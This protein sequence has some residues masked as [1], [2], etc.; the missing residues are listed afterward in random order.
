[1]TA[2]VVPVRKALRGIM[3]ALTSVLV[4]VVAF[5]AGIGMYAAVLASRP[6]LLVWWPWLLAGAVAVVALGAWWLWWRLP[7]R[8]MRSITAADPKARAIA[9]AGPTTQT[10]LLVQ[11]W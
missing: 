7:K 3:I 8:Q 4:I 11:D 5:A 2:A 1:M 6:L 10:D 9:P